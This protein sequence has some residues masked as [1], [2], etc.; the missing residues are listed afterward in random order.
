MECRP[1]PSSAFIPPASLG[2]VPALALDETAQQDCQRLGSLSSSLS[3]SCD[4]TSVKVSSHVKGQ[5]MLQTEEIKAGKPNPNVGGVSRAHRVAMG[6]RVMPAEGTRFGNVSS[7][8]ETAAAAGPHS[9][10][11]RA[12]GSQLLPPPEDTGAGECSHSVT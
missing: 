9:P 7:G 2:Q 8:F 11:R 5:W 1:N 12:L 3:A 6:P 10:S 4:L